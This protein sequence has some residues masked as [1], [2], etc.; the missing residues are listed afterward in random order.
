MSST[1]DADSGSLTVFTA[2]LGD[3]GAGVTNF[4]TF[5]LANSHPEALSIVHEHPVVKRSVFDPETAT[6][7][8]S[9]ITSIDR[10]STAVL[11]GGPNEVL[12]PNGFSILRDTKSDTPTNFSHEHRAQC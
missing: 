9:D 7:S 2:T 5:V 6:I 12:L 8:E 4:R 1:P 11:R 3:A 10:L